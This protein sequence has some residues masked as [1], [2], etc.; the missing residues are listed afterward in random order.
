MTHRLAADLLERPVRVL[1]VGCGGSGSAIAGGLPYLHQAI[2]AR[3]HPYGLEVTFQDG[4]TVS[5]SNCVRQPFSR[6]E[7]GH[8][9]ASILA[10]RLNL[11]WGLNWTAIPRHLTR[12]DKLTLSYDILIGCVD[13]ISARRLIHELA[14]DTVA[15][16]RYWLDLGNDAE[17]GQYVLGQPRNA[18]NRKLDPRLPTVAELYPELVDT[19]RPVP[20]LPSCSAA[21]ALTRQAP[22]VNQVI[23]N[24]ALSLLARLFAGGV[25]HH[26]AFVNLA[27]GRAN[28]L[29][30]PAKQSKGARARRRSK[31]KAVAA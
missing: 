26:G 12:A 31:R 10:T 4:D 3:G 29:P 8:P 22:F 23:A 21:E 19:S 24:H 25:D 6:G 11:F 2:V 7:I 15:D 20:D 13:T 14:T 28:A 18:V 30:V 17:E 5:P 27:T 16:L 9:K 1:V